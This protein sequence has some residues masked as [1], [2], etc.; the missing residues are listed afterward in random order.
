[1]LGRDKETSVD[2]GSP[3]SPHAGLEDSTWEPCHGQ[4]RDALRE[5]WQQHYIRRP[6]EQEPS[7]P[8]LA[9]DGS[10]DPPITPGCFSRFVWRHLPISSYRHTLREVTE[11]LEAAV[12]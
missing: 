5:P 6:S 9:I 4:F 1:E 11:C 10:F 2:V 12:C 8:S 7:G 3:A